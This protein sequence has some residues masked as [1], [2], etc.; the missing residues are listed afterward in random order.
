MCSK[1][2]PLNS[3]NT[4]WHFPHFFFFLHSPTFI[5]NAFDTNSRFFF[6][7]QYAHNIKKEIFD[8][9][10]FTSV[11]LS[12]NLSMGMSAMVR[13][14]SLNLLWIRLTL[15]CSWGEDNLTRQ[16]KVAKL[17][18]NVHNGFFWK[19]ADSYTNKKKT[20][21]RIYGICLHIC[22]F[23][24]HVAVLIWFSSLLFRLPPMQ[25]LAGSSE[26]LASSP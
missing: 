7:Q 24:E 15:P 4:L 17:C 10:V 22:G 21:F 11:P 25:P 9:K 1:R 3:S 26:S 5:E 6:S 12:A 16:S 23:Y 14:Q 18:Q 2:S 19:I 8:C 20:E 13:A